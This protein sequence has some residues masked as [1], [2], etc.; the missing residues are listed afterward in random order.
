M[1]RHKC[2]KYLVNHFYKLLILG[3]QV[4]YYRKLIYMKYSAISINSFIK[5][6]YEEYRNNLKF[7]HINQSVYLLIAD[8]T[9]FAKEYRR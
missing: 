3:I 8:D 5:F 2:N 9:I 4:K 7:I 1:S 6:A